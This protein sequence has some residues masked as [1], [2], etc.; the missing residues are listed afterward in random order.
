[1][2]VYGPGV[3][4]ARLDGLTAARDHERIEAEAPQFAQPGL[5]LEPFALRALGSVRGDDELLDRAQ[6][7]FAALGLHWH[8]AQTERLLAGI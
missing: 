5:L 4:S 1:M 7:R 6:Q 2:W 8:A 3:M